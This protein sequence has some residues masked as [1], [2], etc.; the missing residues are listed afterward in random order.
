MKASH[1]RSKNSR[2]GFGVKEQLLMMLW[3]FAATHVG[4]SLRGP[5]KTMAAPETL[6]AFVGSNLLA[7]SW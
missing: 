5:Q 3:G 7:L 1:L 2:Q 4:V 6:W